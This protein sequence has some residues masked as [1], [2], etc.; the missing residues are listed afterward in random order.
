MGLG[1]FKGRQNTA[2]K[3][4][5]LLRGR[6]HGGPATRYE[7]L[8]PAI[9]LRGPRASVPIT[10]SISVSITHTHRVYRRPRQALDRSKKVEGG[11]DVSHH[12]RICM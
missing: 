6:P 2:A 4:N 12:S 8:V 11:I 5:Q 3:V 10:F 1:N 9:K 7:S